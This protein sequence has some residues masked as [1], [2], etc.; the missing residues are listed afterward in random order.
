MRLFTPDG[1]E[2]MHV[3][4]INKEDDVLKIQGKIMGNMPV[5][6]I[7]NQQ[8]FAEVLS[9]LNWEIIKFV[10]TASLKKLFGKLDSA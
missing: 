2:L 8:Q 6:A 10:I 3:K 7:L 1:N 5:V 9:L 4:Q